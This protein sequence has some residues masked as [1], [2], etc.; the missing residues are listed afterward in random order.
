M[1]NLAPWASHF[2][3][4]P[5]RS[6]HVSVFSWRFV[7]EETRSSQADL[8]EESLQPGSPV[9][10]LSLI[11]TQGFYQPCDQPGGEEGGVHPVQVLEVNQGVQPAWAQEVDEAV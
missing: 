11:L 6:D 1:C 3:S 10:Q 5:N 9:C 8:Q 7:S 2:P 4:A